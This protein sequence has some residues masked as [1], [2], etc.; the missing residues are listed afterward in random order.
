MKVREIITELDFMGHT[1][2]KDC[3]G[4]RAGYGWALSHGG[5]TAQTPSP[6]FNNGTE[7]GNGKFNQ[8]K[9]GG[10]K[11]PQYVSQT[12]N[13]VR[14]RMARAQA[15]QQQQTTVGPVQDTTISEVTAGQY[16]ASN[17]VA[18]LAD[19]PVLQRIFGQY[20][21]GMMQAATDIAQGK[22]SSALVNAF[23]AVAP[24]L[25]LPKFA[26]NGLSALSD[27]QLLSNIVRMGPAAVGTFLML[28]SKGAGEGE[29]A[30]IARIHQQQDRAMKR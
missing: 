13:A 2:T 9:Q 18:R 6:S 4:H 21:P 27:I 5:A 11:F 17:T 20:G 16:V 24:D 26:Q 29:D 7:I 14:K 30:E 23:Q 1:C 15:K 3:S 22:Y 19:S 8:R 25:P 10:G 28:Y 12:P